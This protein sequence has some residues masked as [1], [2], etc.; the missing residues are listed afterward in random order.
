MVM[1][2]TTPR[3]SFFYPA[4]RTKWD[5]HHLYAN[6]YLAGGSNSREES[7][8]KA[9]QRYMEIARQIGWDSS[10]EDDVDLDNLSDDGGET[11][12]ARGGQDVKDGTQANADAWRAHSVMARL[13]GT[14]EE[15]VYDHD[16]KLVG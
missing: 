9:M 4:P 12:G 16:G 11:Q 10:L 7:M 6:T 14:D 2:S 15:W 13:D 3:P 1:K 8:Q 5:A